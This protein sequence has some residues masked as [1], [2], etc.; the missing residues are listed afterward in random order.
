MGR[1][2]DS[3]FIIGTEL[4]NIQEHKPLETLAFVVTFLEIYEAR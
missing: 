4:Y 3:C 2:A 1:H